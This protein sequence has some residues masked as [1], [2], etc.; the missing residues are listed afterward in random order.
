MRIKNLTFSTRIILLFSGFIIFA[1]LLLVI[2]TLTQNYPHSKQQVIKF[3]NP[4]NQITYEKW[5]GQIKQKGGTNAYAHFKTETEKK[6]INQGHTDAHLFGEALYNIEGVEGVSVCDTSFSYG[7]Y[8]SFLGSAIYSQGMDIVEKLSGK[9]FENLKKDGLACQHGI[10][11]GVLSS[12]G[13]D[14]DSVRKSL[15]ICDKLKDKDP[16]GGCPGGVF[17]EYN[18]QTML[19]DEAKTRPFD[20]NDPYFPCFSIDN[21]Y[22]GACF[23]N[24]AQWWLSALSGTFEERTKKI[25][26]LCQNIK[27]PHLQ[28]QCF[29]GFGIN[30]IAQVNY[31]IEKAN[32]ICSSFSSRDA[33]IFCRS[34]TAISL[35]VIPRLKSEGKKFCLNSSLNKH[36]QD[37]C[38]YQTDQIAT[39][40]TKNSL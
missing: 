34:G 1:S 11:H 32:T 37:L 39:S 27:D 17:M 8:H 31:D 28:I 22:I 20:I 2:L 5:L 26:T 10:G 13:Y 24:Q 15:K 23:Y 40:P 38:L 14:L 6:S 4:Q 16:I 25:D 3:S 29:K 33:Q 36:E 21:Y 12:I 7:C 18:F 35:L 30:M 9:C 19:L